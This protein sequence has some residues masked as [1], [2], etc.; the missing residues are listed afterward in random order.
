MKHHGT[1]SG[2]NASSVLVL[3]FFC[4]FSL[5]PSHGFA[6]AQ[7]RERKVFVLDSLLGPEIFAEQG[8]KQIVPQLNE[9][10]FSWVSQEEKELR[11]A[12][13]PMTFNELPV[14]EI[15]FRFNGETL[16]EVFLSLYNRGDAG[17]ISDDAFVEFIGK[18]EKMLDARSGVAGEDLGDALK[19][20]SIR[21]Q[22]KGWLSPT[23]S[24]RLD[25][26]Y[27]RVREDGE[28][29]RT[30][31]PEFVNLTLLKGGLQKEDLL[32]QRKAETSLVNFNERVKR[33]VG[34]DVLIEGIPMVDQGQKGY[35]AVATM[36]RILRYYGS[37]VNQHELAQQANS[38]GQGGTDPES[39]VKAL[40]G[41]GNKL[42]LKID[43]R[44]SF[45]FKDFLDL[46][47][48][49]NRAAKRK[50]ENELDL[51]RSG[52]IHIGEFYQRMNVEV[53]RD[54]KLK[55]SSKV[56]KFFSNT[57]ETIDQGRPLAWS[58]YLGW[59]EE[60][61]KLPQDSGG[62]MRLIIGYNPEKK[63][64]IYSDSWGYGHELKRMSLEDAYLITTGLYVIE[65]RS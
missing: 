25:A 15:I 36:E 32:V 28:S 9:G 60:T 16:S 45:D 39:L 44:Q 18:T 56:E 33:P 24:Y 40:R 48:D 22:S 3:S 21:G 8:K 57:S 17:R 38:S 43:E 55:S 54:V 64:I 23:A 47:A 13:G 27:S 29:R 58:V 59:V 14:L 63:E 30:E 35:C 6:Q 51:P 37:E 34:G 10:P 26:A 49:Y 4:L 42:G 11:G 52:V 50:K 19:S 53:L 5:L 61:P 12:N 41:M 7:K 20:S 65:P 1:T 62:H 2:L 46:V 31:R